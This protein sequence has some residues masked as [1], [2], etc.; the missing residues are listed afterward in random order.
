MLEHNMKDGEFYQS[1]SADDMAK[2][3]DDE[4]PDG[5]ELVREVFTNFTDTLCTD[6]VIGY[7]NAKFK[8]VSATI[9]DVKLLA[10]NGQFKNLERPLTF[11]LEAYQVVRTGFFEILYRDNKPFGVPEETEVQL[12]IHNSPANTPSTTNHVNNQ[13]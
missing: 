12:T 7:K 8:V 4:M 9:G 1:L 6:D 2:M 11:D 5:H 13:P 3:A 10:L